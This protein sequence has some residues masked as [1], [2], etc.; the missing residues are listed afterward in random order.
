MSARTG[1]TVGAA[2]AGLLLIAAA[3]ESRLEQ[4]FRLRAEAGA[5]A[6]AGDLATAEKTFE[7]TLALFPTAPGVLIRLA[8]VEAA[9][10]KP[11]EALGRLATYAGLGLAYDPAQDPAM[12]S[13]TSRPSYAAVA[14]RLAAN[15]RP[16]GELTDMATL[17]PAGVV[18]EGLAR[19]GDD[20]L[21]STVAGRAISR[22]GPDGKMTPLL[23]PDSETG[24]LFG[25][26]I[27]HRRGILWA[28]ETRRPD[29][30]GSPQG[31]QR[32][33]LLKLSPKDGKVLA[34]YVLPDDGELHQ[35][36]D[37]TVADD[38]T[39]YGSDSTS[40]AIYRLRPGDARLEAV[41][42][43]TEMASPQ[44]MVLCPGG[45]AMVIADYSSGLHRL[46]LKTGALQPVGGMRVALAGTDGLFRVG[47]DSW[48]RLARPLPI[49]MV[50][51]QN[52]VTPQRIMLL[53]LSPDCRTLQAATVLAAN[54]PQMDDLTLGADGGGKVVFIGAGGW[55][56]Y[57]D[58][59][60]LTTTTPA[61]AHLLS[62]P[63]P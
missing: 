45:K 23:T 61:T 63:L 53:R 44:G 38:G 27:D 29:I 54:L 37:V 40:A 41:L 60:K 20:W 5:A 52:G 6:K 25:L 42:Q 33:G 22:V 55:A 34:R 39:V 14:A 50:A 32:T 21:V 13:L 18:N 59:G 43:T 35:I 16:V 3:P 56:D 49:D 46:D 62:V 1:R 30:P 58:A 4:Y 7:A 8:R 57:D 9:L 15:S 28:A 48:M 47:R 2:L 19:D 17:G 10:G 12:A 26:A 31:A 36:G 24:G 11:D 51:T